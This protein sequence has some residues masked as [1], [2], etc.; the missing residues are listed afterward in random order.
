MNRRVL[1]LG[2]LLVGAL[3]AWQLDSRAKTDGVGPEAQVLIKYKSNWRKPTMGGDVV[4]TIPGVNV[5]KLQFA[6]K[7]E[8]ED[9]ASALARDTAVAYAEV[10]KP[11]VRVLFTPNDP[12][13]SS[14]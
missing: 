9:A 7:E 1:L 2:A 10:N 11:S 13:Y 14:Q 12:K 8:A 4:A 3:F 6:S 5:R